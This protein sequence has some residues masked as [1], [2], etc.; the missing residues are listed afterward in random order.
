MVILVVSC[1]YMSLVLLVMF[2]IK[3]CFSK[4]WEIEVEIISSKFVDVDSVVVILFV[5][6]SV[7]IYVGKFVILG[8][9]NIMILWLIFILLCLLFE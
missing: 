5:V 3:F 9:V 6:M 1:V 8:L 4:L 2:G 7:I